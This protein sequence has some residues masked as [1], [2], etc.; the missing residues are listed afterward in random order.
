MNSGRTHDAVEAVFALPIAFLGMLAIGVVAV[1]TAP[2]GRALTVLV[3]TC[4]LV[5]TV[6][7][8]SEPRASLPIT[9]LGWFTVA[10]FAA[11]PVGDL[12]AVPMSSF[13]AVVAAGSVGVAAGVWYRSR[14]ARGARKGS[15]GAVFTVTL[16]GVRFH[17]GRGQHDRHTGLSTRRLVGALALAAALLPG[18]TAAMVAARGSLALVDEV[19]FYL[20]AVVLVTLVGG[21]WPAVAAA[22]AAGLLL[23]W[24]FTAPIHTWTIEDPTNLLALLMFVATAVTVSSV[25]HLAARRGTAAA[26]RAAEAD[27]LLGLARTVLVDD[28]P[29][30]VL[31]HLQRALGLT[32]VL[33]ERVAGAWV[34]IA[35]VRPK[36]ATVVVSAGATFRLRVNGDVTA[37]SPRLLEAAAAQAAAAC[38]RQ[39]MRTQAEQSVALTAGNRMR[40][41]LLAAVSHD[42][43]TPL[44]SVK[45]AVSSLRQNDVEWTE[46]DR[47]ALL[48][49]IEE[50]ADRLAGLIGN[51]LDMS[52]IQTGAVEPFLRVLAVDEVLPSV[53]RAVGAGSGVVLHVADDLPLVRTDPVLL[54]RALENLLANAVRYS[55]VDRTVQ[56]VAKHDADCAAVLIDVVDHGPG[57]PIQDRARVFEPFQ[58]LGDRR[59]AGGVGLGLAVAKG[60]VDAVGGRLT[61]SATPG[62]G[63]TMRVQLPVAGRMSHQAGALL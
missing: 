56:V 22:L 58:Q 49:T 17:A 48:A 55:P 41:A 34:R 45:A 38:E 23:N 32:G 28:R 7:A 39:R 26:A 30:T 31:A 11:A 6:S 63:L 57:V 12:K 42:L 1:A 54:E 47:A 27:S 2:S 46:A 24:F 36:Q 15:H 21:F 60:F 53:A 33:E 4:L 50:G 3:L 14:V 25:V 52:R 43:R 37:A 59:T 61:A 13:G 8:A 10:G 44:A 35:G 29:E 5:A 40:T 20:L 62:G 51:L 16:D 9:A 19:L 18:L